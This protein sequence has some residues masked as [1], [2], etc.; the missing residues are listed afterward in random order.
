MVSELSERLCC[1]TPENTVMIKKPE[2][3]KKKSGMAFYSH[4]KCHCG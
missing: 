2:K 4:L 1:D 3:K